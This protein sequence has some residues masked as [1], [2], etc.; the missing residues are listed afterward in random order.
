MELLVHRHGLFDLIVL[1]EDCFR[2]VELLVKDSKLGLN[3]E[4]VDAFSGY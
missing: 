3:S 4:V 2:L 1:D